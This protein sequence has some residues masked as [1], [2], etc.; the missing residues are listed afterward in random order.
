MFNIECIP[1]TI[2]DEVVFDAILLGPYLDKGGLI[3]IEVMAVK[4]SI[5]ICYA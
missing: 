1:H 2:P 5:F 3:F 4:L